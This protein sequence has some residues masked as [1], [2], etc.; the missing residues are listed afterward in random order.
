MNSLANMVAGQNFGASTPRGQFNALHPVQNPQNGQ[1]GEQNNMP[2]RPNAGF[3]NPSVQPPASPQFGG[4]FEQRYPD[5]ATN[6]PAMAG[7]MGNNNFAQ[8]F[9]GM[10]LLAKKA[11][12]DSSF[13]QQWTDSIE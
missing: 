4:N 5:F 9:Q 6:H 2:Y 10:G 12:D 1:N 13:L 3:Q 8:N 7:F 11:I